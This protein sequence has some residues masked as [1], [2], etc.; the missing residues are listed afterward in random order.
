MIILSAVW[1]IVISV[2]VSETVPLPRVTL[3][4]EGST[5]AER[6]EAVK[7]KIQRALIQGKNR[8]LPAH[9]TF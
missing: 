4:P 6:G 1:V 2:S 5:A 7:K 8:P 3:P 9:A